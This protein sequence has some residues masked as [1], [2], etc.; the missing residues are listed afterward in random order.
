MN[1]FRLI[2]IITMLGAIGT[3]N[4]QAQ[5]AKNYKSITAALARPDSVEWLTLGDQNLDRFPEEILRFRNLKYLDLSN[6]R[7]SKLP[8][9]MGELKNLF[10]LD[11]SGNNI[12]HLPASM[13][14]ISSL[15]NIYLGYNK[16]E[17]G[18]GF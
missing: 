15:R 2:L 4:V 9:N 10:Y 17:N 6:N 16:P 8:D 3:V 12:S 7:I 11:L 18:K 1:P 13:A 5:K 14:G